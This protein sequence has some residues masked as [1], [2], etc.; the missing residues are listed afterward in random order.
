V[1]QNVAQSAS[2][3]YEKPTL[4]SIISVDIISIG[5]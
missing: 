3:S 2:Q 1:A 4:P 5:K